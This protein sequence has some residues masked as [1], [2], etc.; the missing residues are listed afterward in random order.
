MK[1][2]LRA[3]LLALLIIVLYIEGMAPHILLL[4]ALVFG[5]LLLFRDKI[6]N[7]LHKAVGEIHFMKGQAQ[8]MRYA[9]A[10]ILFIAAFY[11]LKFILFFL[12]KLAGY[13]LEMELLNTM[14]AR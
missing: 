13:D 5:L 7:G 14:N 9:V 10:L 3:A 1:Q 6:W 8:W 4:F 12:L 2:W 11:M